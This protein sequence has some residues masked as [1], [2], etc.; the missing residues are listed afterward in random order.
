MCRLIIYKGACVYIE[1]VLIKPENSLLRQSRSATYHPGCHDPKEIRNI[2]VNGD[3]FGVAW[4]CP[5]TLHLGSCVFKFMTPAWSNGNLQNISAHVRAPVI[6]GHVRAASSGR[7]PFENTTVSYENCHPFKF[8]RYT[9][10]HNGTVPSF[11]KVKRVLC[12]IINEEI[13]REI[14]GNTDSEHIFGLILHLLPNRTEQLSAEDMAYAVEETIS[15][16]LRICKAKG[17]EEGCSLNFVLTDGIHIISTR[18]RSDSSEAP[19]LYYHAKVLYHKG[20]LSGGDCHRSV[21]S[22]WDQWMS[23]STDSADESHPPKISSVVISSEPQ[24]VDDISSCENDCMQSDSDPRAI[25][26]KWR[27]IPKNHVLLVSGDPTN[28][29]AVENIICRPMVVGIS[30]QP[31]SKSLST[32]FLLHYLEVPKETRVSARERSLSTGIP[33][34]AAWSVA[35]MPPEYSELAMP[36]TVAPKV[37]ATVQILPAEQSWSPK[38]ALV[39]VGTVRL[40]VPVN[41]IPQP[42]KREGSSTAILN[43]LKSDIGIKLDVGL[44]SAI[45]F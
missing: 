38:Q 4:Y 22:D 3:G 23:P 19:S 2:R 36:A 24:W 42:L 43:P 6:I 33:T 34:T 35:Q 13:F 11:S 25:S 7:N 37:P 40:D 31:V 1:E 39:E 32:E 27:L 15:V 29:E 21:D 12:A 5:E 41:C 28:L 30:K 45:G 8:G 9:F 44:A 10:V 20:I 18:F 26:G 14:L 17:V 16:I